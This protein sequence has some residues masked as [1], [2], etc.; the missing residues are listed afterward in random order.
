MARTLAATVELKEVNWRSFWRE[1]SLMA[2]VWE[3]AEGG[4]MG[5][6]T[7][8]VEAIEWGIF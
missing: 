8:L 4:I 2:W 5:F 3:T 7:F 6:P 1:E